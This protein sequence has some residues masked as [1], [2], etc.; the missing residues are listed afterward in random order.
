MIHVQGMLL[1]L[2]TPAPARAP[3]SEDDFRAATRQRLLR[4]GGITAGVGLGL[5]ALGLGLGFTVTFFG[6]IL[7]T[8]AGVALL[9]GII[10]MIVS[11][12]IS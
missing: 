9:A 5:L 10:V 6:F 8:L 2:P 7:A 11:A 3:E 1:R 4:A 12:A